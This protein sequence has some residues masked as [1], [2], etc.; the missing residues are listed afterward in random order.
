MGDIFEI[1]KRRF[2]AGDHEQIV[3]AGAIALCLA[4]AGVERLGP[5]LRAAG[6]D[7]KILGYDHNWTTHPGD[8]ASTPPGED[9]ET[10]Y[11]YKLLGSPASRWLAGT[12]Y[13]C[14]SGDRT[15]GS[16]RRPY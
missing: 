2:G 5:L 8:V 13:H 9:P 14:Y 1:P 15:G 16:H 7:T 12:A 6:L 4:V 3:D 10:D 11:P